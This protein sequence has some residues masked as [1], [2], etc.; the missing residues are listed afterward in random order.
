MKFDEKYQRETA[1]FPS[2]DIDPR[3][4]LTK[5]YG[6]RMATAIYTTYVGDKASFPYSLL[7][8]YNEVRQYSDGKQDPA[9]Y[10]ER[11]NPSDPDQSG[12]IMTSVDGD[13]TSKQGKRKGLG[14]LNREILSLG[15]RIMQA[16]LGS[17][18]DVDYNL[19]A[20]TIDPDSGFEQE[21]MKSKIY[22]ESQHL[23]FLNTIKQQAGIPTNSD[24]KYPKDLDE[25]QLMD[26]LGEFKT[27]I[28]KALEKLLKHTYEISDWESVKEKLIKDIV[29]FN[30]VC[31]H[32]YYDYEECKWKTDYED[33]T[34]VIAQ[35]SDKRDYAD[36]CYFGIIREKTVSEIR[37]KLEDVGYTEEEIGQLAQNWGGLL[38]NPIQSQWLD[39][40]QKD[41]YGNWMYDFYKCLVLETEWIDNDLEYKTI[42]TSRRGIISIYDQDFGRVRDT[43]HN[44]TR[45]TTIK[46][47]YEAKWVIGSDLIYDHR[48]SPSQPRDNGNKRPLMSFHIYNGT[49]AAITQRLIPIFDNF[50]ITWLKLQNEIAESFGEILTLDQSVLE[51]ITMGGEKWDTL[52]ILKH[53]K[54]THVLP[55]RSLP[56]NG[57]YGG[58]SV[59]PIDIIPS[60]LMNRIDEAIKL[61]ENAIRMVE[62]V[63][64]INPVSLGSQPSGKQGLGQTEISIQN[65][66]KI[67]RP[68]VD[69]IFTVK[70]GSAEFLAGAIR[71]ALR[72]DEDCRRSYIPVIG[73]NDVDALANSDYDSRQLGIRLIPRPT[74]EELQSLYRDIETASMPG[75]DGKPLIRFDVKLYIKEKL[76]RGAN[77]SDI[78]LYLSNA[79]DK[80]LDRQEKERQASIQAQG[81]Q[82]SQLEQI[83]SKTAAQNVQMNIKAQLMIE[84]KKHEHNMDLEQLKQGMERY[85]IDQESKM[86]EQESNSMQNAGQ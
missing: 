71:L 28:A 86:K 49:E 59:K 80:E 73:N 5:D 48:L 67:L 41:R 61:F 52:K 31:L 26:D 40:N 16:I 78:R 29:N 42:N 13:W 84:D 43:D 37:H 63:T 10:E 23:D 68:I 76:M 15:P 33:V 82:N 64:G 19:V 74:T 11:M 81:Q 56:I 7:F 45:V 21:W 72:N 51:R 32:D 75:K 55:F 62:Y 8:Y 38:S 60:T 34:R 12:K 70:T 27:G 18:K 66:T 36:S 65:T 20:E 77:I 4:K 2:R 83:K 69:A 46:R 39:F 6:I 25:L 24:T 50:Q 30:A 79:I 53:A 47:K 3:L 22:A 14:N 17:F 44:K 85:K 35:F 9:K 1:L 54:K 57:K 58:G